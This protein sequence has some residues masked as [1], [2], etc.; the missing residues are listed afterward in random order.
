MK[1]KV[2]VEQE[3]EIKTLS[4]KAG[5]RYWEDAEVNGVEESELSKRDKITKEYN[6]VKDSSVVLTQAS[7]EFHEFL[8]LNYKAPIKK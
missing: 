2:K 4:V 3:V 6:E 5:V 1:A 7:R 8:V